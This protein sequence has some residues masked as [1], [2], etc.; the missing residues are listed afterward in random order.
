MA[1][2]E[3]KLTTT[4]TQAAHLWLNSHA[5]FLQRPYVWFQTKEFWISTTERFKKSHKCFDLCCP[6]SKVTGFSGRT[7]APE[8]RCDLPDTHTHTH[9][10]TP[11]RTRMRKSL[12]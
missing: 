12:T 2:H 5:Y 8:V 4:S 10:H 1:I 7:D 9:A 11:R 3:T 6:L